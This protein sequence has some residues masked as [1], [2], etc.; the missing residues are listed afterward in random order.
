MTPVGAGARAGEVVV[1]AGVHGAGNVGV[2][3]LLAAPR[4]VGEVEAAVHHRPVARVR[5]REG[6]GRDKSRMDHVRSPL[7]VVAAAAGVEDVV[8][9]HILA[10]MAGL[11]PRPA[12][13]A[14][15]VTGRASVRR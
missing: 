4:V 6:L 10:D 7:N 1:Q 8:G 9:W 12:T 14:L 5:R 11:K 3:V 2:G 15:R 13:D